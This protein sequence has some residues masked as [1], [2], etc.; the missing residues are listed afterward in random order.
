M[1]IRGSTL[2]LMQFRTRT[3]RAV[4]RS[5]RLLGCK[6]QGLLLTARTH[7]RGFQQQL[8]V[9]VLSVQLRASQ[10]TAGRIL[11][12]LTGDEE[13]HVTPGNREAI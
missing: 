9:Q 5:Q 10:K 6:N 7:R 8:R 12:I 13:E 11:L 4:L 1:S 3:L 2:L